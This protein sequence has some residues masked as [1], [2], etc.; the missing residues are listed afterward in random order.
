MDRGELL[1]E[2]L[3]KI[4]VTQISACYTTVSDREFDIIEDNNGRS[5][6][7]K[8]AAPSLHVT[9]FHGCT[10]HFIAVDNCVFLSS[11]NH[12][13]N[14]CI[15]FGDS[16]F[17]FIELKLKVI[18]DK[19]E[20]RRQRTEK[21]VSQL[22]ATVEYFKQKFMG[23]S[24]NF[25][26]LGF[27]YEA[28]IVLPTDKYP[29]DSATAKSRRVNFFSRYGVRLFERNLKEFKRRSSTPDTT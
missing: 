15:I 1:L 4:F 17:C 26:A 20:T 2:D 3:R 16:D 12:E 21:A 11:D 7:V 10:I 18:S 22:G 25:L 8:N 14:D 24:K 19:E 9:N 5:C 23:Q 29:R 13:R 28:Y 6:V 27:N